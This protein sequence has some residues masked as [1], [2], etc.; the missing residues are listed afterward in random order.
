MHGGK[1]NGG[2]RKGDCYVHGLHF[3]VDIVVAGRAG[4]NPQVTD[5]DDRQ[6]EKELLRN[7]MRW[8]WRLAALHSAV[9]SSSCMMTTEVRNL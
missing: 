3:T 1:G 9:G 8:R 7:G 5:T 4:E 2:E 6:E